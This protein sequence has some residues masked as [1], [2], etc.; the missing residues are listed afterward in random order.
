MV[1]AR[2]G[3]AGS[4]S[5]LLLIGFNVIQFMFGGG[6]S[7]MEQTLNHKEFKMNLPD[8]AVAGAGL[9]RAGRAA[10]ALAGS[11]C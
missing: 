1:S 2:K 3:E 4:Q 10:L 11:R 5:H 8:T 6:E 7:A 9:R